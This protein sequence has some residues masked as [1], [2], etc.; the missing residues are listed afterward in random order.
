MKSGTALQK[1]LLG[2]LLCFT[3]LLAYW[4]AARCGFVNFDDT[5]YVTENFQVQTGLTLKGLAWAFRT[6]HAANWHPLTWLSHM[7]DAQLYGLQP[8]GHHLTS[9]CLHLANTVLLFLLFNRMT[10]ALWRSALVAALF[11]LHPTHVES[12]AWVS[13]RKDVLSGFFFML[14]LLAYARYAEK[15][16]VS[17][18]LS[19]IS[20]QSSVVR[21]REEGGKGQETESSLTHHA[22][23]ITLHAPRPYLLS[24]TF[25]ALGL[26]S[27]PMLVTLPFVLLLLDY[28]PLQR[29]QSASRSLKPPARK[30][31]PS[32]F[33]FHPLLLEKLPF[34][35]LS[36]L[37]SA[38]TYAVQHAGGATVS[39]AELSL[40]GRVANVLVS[41]V[42]YLGKLVWP[43]DLTVFYPRPA[44]WPAWQVAGSALVL[45]LL[46]LLAARLLSRA[47]YV[48]VGWCWFLGT[49]VPVIG[50]VQVGEQAMADRYTY[51]PSI[52]LFILIAWGTEEIAR[53]SHRLKL[54]TWAG[55]LCA[56]AAL[57]VA[58]RAQTR[59]WQNTETLFRQAVAVTKDNPMA[60]E[61]LGSALSETGNLPEA[62]F[63]CL[64]AL[65]L[66]PDFPDAE[67]AYAAILA[68]Q[69]KFA[70]AR[71]RL[72]AVLR[73][74]PREASA[75]FSLAQAFNL[76]GDTA[77]AINQYREGLHLQLDHPDAL[78]N[79]AWIRAA[80]SNPAFR[81]GGE[82]VQLAQRACELTRY[83]RP[84]MV[85]TLA[86]AYAEAGRFDEAIATAQ[87]ACALARTT[88]QEDLAVKNQKLLD[89]YQ[90]HQPYHEPAEL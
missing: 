55:A 61:V 42:R 80:H 13:E 52:G 59:H 12:V 24:L 87:K 25:F 36:A 67:I 81:N 84:I 74:H 88:G 73:K 69:G 50:L 77:Q 11:A 2:L 82:A 32:S 78:N 38:V 58:T 53:R 9:L 62:E 64:E 48:P 33:I 16:V 57:L 75:Y 47:R 8:A 86:A 60:Q 26:M 63:H 7:L 70:A 1:L 23:R 54:L 46:T 37:S 18:Q 17:D 3:A 56:L 49:L 29:S 30:F 43:A 72:A 68:R 89:L 44:Q 90:A 35:L 14:T 65:R 79:L 20:N 39:T 28:W 66:R 40:P 4:P 22:P 51:L 10:G 71:T 6:G 45:A 15:S 83:Q 76:S 85:G 34:F 21:S 41:Y 5:D 27:K 19:V 31:H